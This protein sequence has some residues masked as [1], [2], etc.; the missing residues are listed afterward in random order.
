VPGHATHVVAALALL[1][2]CSA[3][4]KAPR[5]PPAADLALP[6]VGAIRG[7]AGGGTALYAALETGSTPATTTVRAQRRGDEAW[8]VDLPGRGGPLAA[9]PTL[10]AATVT[11]SAA[12]GAGVVR[13]DPAAAIVA[14][15]AAT[16]ARRWTVLV[17]STEWA[18]VTAI[19]ALHADFVVAGTFGGTLRA[20]SRVVSSAGRSDGFVVRLSPA[21]EVRWLVRVGGAG[22]DGVQGVATAGDRIAIAGTFTA[23]AE[24]GGAPLPAYD[25]SSPLGDAF[26]AELDD[27]GARRWTATF[28][29]RA[30]DT[31]AG[32]AI[33]GRGNVVVAASTRDVVHVGSAQLVTQGAS[34]G[35]VAWFGEGGEQGPAVLL[36]GLDFDGLRAITATGGVVI[37]GG[38]FSG[39]IQ[40][41]DRT[42][43]A[44][45][46]DDAFIAA[47]DPS[48]TVAMAWHVSGKGREEVTSLAP[49]PGGFVTG[50][51]HTAAA[52]IEDVQLPAP[53]DPMQG[54]ALVVRGLR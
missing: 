4:P 5:V 33:D 46:G 30:D 11:A 3:R 7:V 32:V 38:F 50:I 14:L 35:I 21:G 36:G 48:G 9:T 37:V 10:V 52:A 54:S 13:G 31:V 18:L 15:D 16:G 27:S 47:L 29:G 49:I 8:H 12:L 43:T 39:S 2:A 28:G 24:L 45:G 42:L 41:A 26:A 19:A 25:E 23:G 44:G 6:L 53:K 17:D 34:D 1:S 51:A 40:L 22:A 20:G